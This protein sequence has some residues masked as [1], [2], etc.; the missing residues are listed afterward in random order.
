MS[1]TDTLFLMLGYVIIMTM[2]VLM[3]DTSQ[4]TDVYYS[5]CLEDLEAVP[6]I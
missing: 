2:N 1:L 3:Q 4:D 6:R 5:S